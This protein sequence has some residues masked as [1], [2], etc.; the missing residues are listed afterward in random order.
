[1]STERV[2]ARFVSFSVCQSMPRNFAVVSHGPVD[3]INELFAYMFVVN[4]IPLKMYASLKDDYL[5]VSNQSAVVHH[6]AMSKINRKLARRLATPRAITHISFNVK[7]VKRK[8]H[9]ACYR[10]CAT[11]DCAKSGCTRKFHFN[12]FHCICIYLLIYF[13]A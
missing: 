6:S 10:K 7:T 2:F 5:K 3:L 13:Y 9:Q 4:I 8:G 11:A 1:M 12:S